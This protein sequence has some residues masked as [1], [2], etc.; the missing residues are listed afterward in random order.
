MLILHFLP[1]GKT[2]GQVPLEYA[3]ENYFKDQKLGTME[4]EYELEALARDRKGDDNDVEMD[5]LKAKK[6]EEDNEGKTAD[7]FAIGLE[8]DLFMFPQRFDVEMRND[9]S[10]TNP[11]I[12]TSHMEHMNLDAIETTHTASNV[13]EVAGDKHSHEHHNIAI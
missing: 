4:N 7:L 12:H 9:I 5:V 1:G 6:E 8:E 13:H 2:A 10:T 3:L 11:I